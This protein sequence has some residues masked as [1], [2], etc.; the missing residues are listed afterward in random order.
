[1]KIIAF[2]ASYSKDSINKKLAAHAALHLGFEQTEIL[3]LNHYLLPLF[4][5]D[6]EKEIGQPQA[7]KDFVEKIEE[8]DVLVISLS[9]H[10]GTYTTAFKNLFDWASRIKQQ[11]FE[12]KKIVLLSTAPGPR[13]G[14]SAL[15]AAKI[16]FPIHGAEIVGVFSLP[17]F[18]ENFSEEEGILNENLKQKLDQVLYLAKQKIK[19]SKL[20]T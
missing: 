15:E 4:T 13:G 17:H 3:D 7:A 16:R 10:N 12:N 20:I 9:E 8:A 6:L 19:L 18:Y 2:G 5:V 14:I 11:M 1:M